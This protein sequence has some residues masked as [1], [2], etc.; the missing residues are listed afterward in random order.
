MIT[1]PMPLT[2]GL[3]STSPDGGQA[4][5]SWV[6]TIE[7]SN[8]SSSIIC[9]F[10]HGHIVQGVRTSINNTVL[11]QWSPINPQQGATASVQMAG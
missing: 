2:I 8:T 7:L 11:G 6:K 10:G 3:T 5:A 9:K 1:S 4:L